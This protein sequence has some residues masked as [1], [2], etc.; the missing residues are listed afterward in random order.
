GVIELMLGL[1]ISGTLISIITSMLLDISENVKAG[2]IPYRGKGHIIIMNHSSKLPYLLDELDHYYHHQD[3]IM[4]I[5]LLLPNVDDLERFKAG[6]NH[7]QHIDIFCIYGEPLNINTYTR[8]NIAQA[9][10]FIMLINPDEHEGNKKS[11]IFINKHFNLQSTRLIIETND[12]H[13]SN[14]IYQHILG[15]QNYLTVNHKQILSK[16]L[17]RSIVDYRYFSLYADLFSFHHY[18][19]YTASNPH[20]HISFNA[21][22]AQLSEAI[23]IGINRAGKTIINPE[24]NPQL[25]PSDTLIYIAHHRHAIDSIHPSPSASPTPPIHLPTPSLVEDKSVCIIGSYNDFDVHSISDFLSQSIHQQNY[26]H[27]SELFCLDFWQSIQDQGYDVIILNLE[28][29]LE[30]ELA[31]YLRACFKGDT[32]FLASIINIINDPIQAELLIDPYLPNNFILSEKVVAQ[33]LALSLFHQDLQHIFNEF[34]SAHGNELYIINIQTQADLL[35]LDFTHFKQALLHNGM[36]Y[37]G[38]YLV[39]GFVFNSPCY[40]QAEAIVVIFQGDTS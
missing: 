13:I 28:D 5:V 26:T 6:L 24:N 36:I 30:L 21:L 16:V 20:H 39:Q 31:L 17:N 1:L 18:T 29:N 12:S 11:T 33:Y 10:G 40:A 38:S 2:L 19:I 22:Y 32:T 14:K 3:K 34:T 8:V 4:D 15:E 7:Y 37:L 27:K 35:Q 9:S 23:L 25:Q